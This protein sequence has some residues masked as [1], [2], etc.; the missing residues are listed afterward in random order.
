[1]G[2]AEKPLFL[3]PMKKARQWWHHVGGQFT[4][5]YY[6]HE[7]FSKVLKEI[8][9]QFDTRSNIYL[10]VVDSGYLIGGY[11]GVA[12]LGSGAGGVAMINNLLSDLAGYDYLAS[13]EL[14]HTFGLSPR[15]SVEI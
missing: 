11:P 4:A 14:R 15:F 9:A 13:H 8:Q 10:V 7:T 1:M 6:E 3:K 12:T 5:N 2:L